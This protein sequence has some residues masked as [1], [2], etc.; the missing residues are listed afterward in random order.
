VKKIILKTLTLNNFATFKNQTIEFNDKFNAIVGETGSG[1]SLIVEALQLIW[2]NRA[3]KSIIRKDAEFSCVE[4]VFSVTSDEIKQYFLELGFP[5]DSDEVVLKRTIDRN[6]KS[7][8]YVNHFTCKAQTL[9]QICKRFVD[10]VGQFENQK[11]LSSNYQLRLLDQYA[12]LQPMVEEYTYLYNQLTMLNKKIEQIQ[13]NST[14]QERRLDYINYQIELIEKINPSIQEEIDLIE[15]KSKI[16][17]KEKHNDAI[18]SINNIISNENDNNGILNLILELTKK[19]DR[20]NDLTEILSPYRQLL[21][22]SFNSI[23]Q[24]QNALESLLDTDEEQDLEQIITRLDQYQQ[25]KNKFR[26]NNIEDI[27]SLYQSFLTEKNQLVLQENN[28]TQVQA[29]IELIKMN[30]HSHANNLHSSRIKA[31][32]S[33]SLQLT[34]YIQKLNMRGATIA[35]KVDAT[36]EFNQFGKNSIT[37]MAETNPGEGEYPLKKI[38]SGGELSR[39]LLSIRKVLS[40]QDSISIF[41]FDEIDTGVGG[42]TALTIGNALHEVSLN[43]QVIAISHLPQIVSF[44]DQIQFVSKNKILENSERRTISEVKVI[45]GKNNI[46][47]VAISL[48]PI[49]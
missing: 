15:S 45:Q 12:E 5:C 3:D 36:M 18:Q 40:S 6:G 14:D 10:L 31:A 9:T 41:L 26:V 23:N 34:N 1:K 17:N 44:A 8:S 28:L 25:L 49:N 30:L 27:L 19:I 20:N 13:N 32:K 29:Q 46:K 35:V 24:F 16:I 37:I 11:L 33:L 7:R 38:A 4:A 47:E 42:E 48:S 43:S 22:D 2:G 39:I 21:D